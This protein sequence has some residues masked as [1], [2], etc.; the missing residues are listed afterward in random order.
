MTSPNEL[1]QGNDD[2]YR[3][4]D[5]FFFHFFFTGSGVIEGDLCARVQE[6]AL[7]GGQCL[8]T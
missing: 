5:N 8:F 7:F 1:N 2:G 4:F 3:P 6:A